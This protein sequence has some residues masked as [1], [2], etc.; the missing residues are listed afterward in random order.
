MTTF[1]LHSRG[2]VSTELLRCLRLGGVTPAFTLILDE[3]G[4]WTRDRRGV[5][6]SCGRGSGVESFDMDDATGI[7]IDRA[8]AAVVCPDGRSTPYGALVRLALEAY[9]VRQGDFSDV[10]SALRR[11]DR[12]GR[13]QGIERGRGHYAVYPLAYAASR[14]DLNGGERALLARRLIDYGTRRWFEELRKIYGVNDD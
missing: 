6:P 13:A 5:P 10:A 12:R 1:A 4:R 9:Y 2:R 14:S 8:L 3:W 7:L 11:R